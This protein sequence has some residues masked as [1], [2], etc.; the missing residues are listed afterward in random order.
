MIFR[1]AGDPQAALAQ[2]SKCIEDL[3][4]S[5]SAWKAETYFELGLTYKQL[6]QKEEA[7]DAFKNAVRTARSSGLARQVNRYLQE[8]EECDEVQLFEVWLEE[9]PSLGDNVSR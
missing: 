3:Q 7:V 8:L 1:A 6:Q 4:R 9:L 5:S 2:F